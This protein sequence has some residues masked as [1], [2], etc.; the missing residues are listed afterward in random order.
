MGLEYA[1]GK[2]LRQVDLSLKQSFYAVF[3]SVMVDRVLVT[4][5]PCTPVRIAGTVSL[6]FVEF[7]WWVELRSHRLKVMKGC[8]V[9]EG[10]VHVVVKDLS[11]SPHVVSCI[12]ETLHDCF[13]IT[14][15]FSPITPV[16]VDSGCRGSQSGHCSCSGGLAGGRY[17]IGPVEQH[18]TPGQSL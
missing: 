12:H 3:C 9:V 2:E 18:A 13:S 5:R 7:L 16:A 8:L 10:S 4:F 1:A 6:G 14:Y 11:R 15:G 17:A